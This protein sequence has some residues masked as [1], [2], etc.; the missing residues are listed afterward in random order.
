MWIFSGRIVEVT[1]K[2]YKNNLTN[3]LRSLCASVALMDLYS[4]HAVLIGV[5]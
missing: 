5:R 3:L 2:N 4:V 1:K